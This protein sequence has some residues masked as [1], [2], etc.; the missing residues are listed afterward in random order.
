MLDEATAAVD[1]DTDALIQVKTETLSHTI[2][3]MLMTN[4]TSEIVFIFSK[5]LYLGKNKGI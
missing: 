5:K 4:C 1:V 3:Q 2:I